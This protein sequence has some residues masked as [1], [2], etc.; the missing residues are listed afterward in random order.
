M[1]KGEE[2]DSAEGTS[3]ARTIV[4]ASKSQAPNIDLK[5]FPVMMRP[6]DPL[7][8]IPNTKVKPRAAEGTWLET[9]R[10]NRRLPE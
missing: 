9:A 2:S 1:V 5:E 3:E 10:E 4:Q 8:P 6:W 7:V